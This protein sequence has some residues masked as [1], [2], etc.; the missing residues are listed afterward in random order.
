MKVVCGCRS[1]LVTQ[2]T[3]RQPSNNGRGTYWIPKSKLPFAHAAEAS[4]EDVSI[5]EENGSHGPGSFMGFLF[6]L[7]EIY[8]SAS[9]KEQDAHLAVAPLPAA[10]NPW[11]DTL[12][13]HAGCRL[14][15]ATSNYLYL[16]LEGRNQLLNYKR[17]GH[18]WLI[19]AL[20]IRLSQG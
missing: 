16:M 20:P 3:L 7:K 13:L 18:S 19:S 1:G 2:Q 17:S 10:Q 9:S 4:C 11:Q 8:R 6:L 12:L 14:H 5:S 15:G